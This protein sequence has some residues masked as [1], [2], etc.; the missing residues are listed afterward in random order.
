VRLRP[1][2]WGSLADAIK[3]GDYDAISKAP[4][5]APFTD[6]RTAAQCM[7]WALMQENAYSDAVSA[8]KSYVEFDRHVQDLQKAAKGVLAK[9]GVP[10]Q[11]QQQFMLLNASLEALL[12]AVP[13]K[14]Q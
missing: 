13:A 5:Q 9:Q 4:F 10:D 2:V 11:V 14:Y 1:V 12:G 7:S 3:G 6:L 8:A